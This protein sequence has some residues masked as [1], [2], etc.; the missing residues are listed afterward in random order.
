MDPRSPWREHSLC[1]GFPDLF[2]PTG[3]D[4]QAKR[5]VQAAKEVCRRC[6]VA[7]HCRTWVLAA[8]PQHGVWGGL[9]LAEQRRI[10]RQRPVRAQAA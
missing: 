3:T 2:F 8:G 6:P 4:A 9:T 5:Q 10:R 7:E 1:S